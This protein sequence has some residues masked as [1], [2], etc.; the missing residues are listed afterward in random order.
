MTKCISYLLDWPKALRCYKTNVSEDV[1]KWVLSHI[2][3]GI[4][5]FYSHIR[6]QFNRTNY[7][8]CSYLHPKE[9]MYKYI[10]YRLGMA[11]QAC[12]LSILGGQGGQITRSGV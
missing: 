12:N 9:Q 2:A 1:G 6:E 11:A 10:Y 5:T 7:L 8:K 3:G 4:I